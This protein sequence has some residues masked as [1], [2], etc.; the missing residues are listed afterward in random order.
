MHHD[1][2]PTASCG[3][4]NHLIDDAASVGQLGHV[5]LELDILLLVVSHELELDLEVLGAL[6]GKGGLVRLSSLLIRRPGLLGRDPSD[7][8]LLEKDEG[9][10]SVINTAEL[11]LGAVLDE[12][13]L[14]A[15]LHLPDRDLIAKLL[16][17]ALHDVVALSVDDQRGKVIERGL[18]QV[19][20][21]EAASVLSAGCG[22]SV[23]GRDAEAGAHGEAE[24]CMSAVLLTKLKD[25]RVEI[26]A[27]VDDRVLE[28]TIAARTLALASCSVLL[29]LL[30]VAYTMVAHVLAATL[31]ANLEVRVAVELRNAS[32]GDTALAVKAIDILA[33]DVFQVLL[34]H[35]LN[36]RHVS[37]GWVGLLDGGAKG[38]CVVRLTTSS[39]S[40]L[41]LLSVPLLVCRGFPAAWA[42]FENGVEA[43]SVV[44]DSTGCRDASACERY[45]VA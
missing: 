33:D 8:N 6:L 14:E 44:G 38:T 42:S 25:S 29:G 3:V 12:A 31:L 41:L 1:K 30:S 15:L 19:A 23:G 35:E 36:E 2:L 5:D 17:E 40:A 16:H 34:L 43:R 45:K 7:L 27:E 26:L 20:N 37:E 32:C 18:L 24:V 10:A 28:V 39:A 21:D 4:E 9:Q 22:H 11:N 13:D